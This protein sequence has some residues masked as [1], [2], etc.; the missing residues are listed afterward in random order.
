MF[1]NYDL[2]WAKY[3]KKLRLL[4]LPLLSWDLFSNPNVA[5]SAFNSLQ[6]NWINKEDYHNMIANKS[7]IITDN[8]LT[9]VFATKEI[10]KLTGYTT[11]EIIG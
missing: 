10:S 9:I 5:I 7:V 2:A 8:K 11:S 1:D 6:K 3:H 4:P